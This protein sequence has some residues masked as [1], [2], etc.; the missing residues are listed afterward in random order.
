MLL[1][2]IKV[3]NLKE[4]ADRWEFTSN[5]LDQLGVP[6]ERY[7]ARRPIPITY[8]CLVNDALTFGWGLDTLVVNDDMAFDSL[9]YPANAPIVTLW[10]GRPGHVCPRAFAASQVGWEMLDLVWDGHTKICHAW[11]PLVEK[12]GTILDNT[13]HRWGI[14]RYGEDGVPAIKIVEAV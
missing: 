7:P 8:R 9:A 1:V 6:Y 3:I 4:D 2:Q 5:Y 10:R 14:R 12:V 13:S 11:T